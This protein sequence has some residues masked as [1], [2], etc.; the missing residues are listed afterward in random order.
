MK[1]QYCIKCLDK[2]LLNE[3]EFEWKKETYTCDECGTVYNR[4][5]QEVCFEKG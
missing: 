2:G 5:M 3:M 1:T 4:R